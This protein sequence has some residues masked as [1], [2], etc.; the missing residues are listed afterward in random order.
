[1]NSIVQQSHPRL[2]KRLAQLEPS[3]TLGLGNRIAQLRAQGVSII[4][5]GQGE[6]DF[7]TPDPIKA[8]AVTAIEQNQTRYTPTGGF[9]D[10]KR[11]VA[12]RVTGDTGITYTPAQISVTTGAKEAIF[13]ALQAL[14]DEG[15]E[16]IVPAPYWVSYVEQVRLSGATPVII[17]TDETT[18][19]KVSAA[20]L[21]ACLTPQTRAI[22]LNTPSNPTGVVYTADELRALADVLRTSEAVI[23]SDEIYD[24][25]CYVDYARWLRVAP[26]FA[27]R[28]LVINGASKTYAMTGWRIGYVAGPTPIVSAIQDIQSHSTT[29]PTSIAQHAALAAFRPS[30]ELD[31]TVA[32]MV[33]AFQER[34]DLI[35]AL[36]E[37]MAGVTCVQPN[38]AF[39]VFPN[40]AG[41]LQR[42]LANGT[43]CA[44]SDDLANY[45]LEQARIGVVPGEAFGAPGYLRLSYAQSNA[46]IQEGMR[47]F[48]EAIG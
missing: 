3:A 8:A 10:L 2:S 44:S 34:R 37:Q 24:A 33:Q 18:H 14:C 1:M 41:L 42:P 30:E 31:K 13:L 29:H 48:A 21:A 22:I 27:N 36:L 19:F 5:F 11:A 38:G 32:M 26:E 20:Q 45:L 46:D 43:V 9:M 6:P 47:R 23:I 40:V 15:D 25:I 4:S 28:T 35:M 39:Y 12:E 7:P 16:V 17:P